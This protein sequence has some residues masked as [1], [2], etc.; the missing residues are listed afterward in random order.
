MKHMLK[1]LLAISLLSSGHAFGSHGTDPLVVAGGEGAAEGSGGSKSTT[2]PTGEQPK[3]L[4]VGV[5]KQVNDQGDTGV[6]K[7]SDKAD[8]VKK[9]LPAQVKT[10][11]EAFDG[12]FENGTLLEKYQ[13][14]APTDINE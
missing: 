11:N 12:L 7:E 13:K 14:T 6:A 5:A 8:S 4:P 10:I 9:T 2:P 1:Y 3:E